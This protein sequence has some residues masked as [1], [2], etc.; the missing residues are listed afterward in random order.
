MIIDNFSGY[1][2]DVN[3]ALCCRIKHIQYKF[4]RSKKIRIREKWRKQ[5]KNYKTIEENFVY[6]VDDRIIMS[7]K[8]YKKLKENKNV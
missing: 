3:D 4:P 1:D 8:I 7:S 5:Q 6:K 2:I